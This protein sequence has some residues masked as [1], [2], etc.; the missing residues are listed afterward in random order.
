M[1][2]PVAI[3]GKSARRAKAVHRRRVLTVVSAWAR[4]VRGGRQPGVGGPRGCQPGDAPV[5]T[6]P[7]RMGFTGFVHD[8]TPEAV[9]ASRTLV[10]ENGDILTHHI[11]GVPWA[12]A[13]GGGP[14]P[15]AFLD[16]W[17]G[18]KS[19]TPPG[20][21]VYLAISPGRGELK[22]AEKAGPIPKELAGK[23]YDDPVVMAACLNYCRRAI[24]FFK[25]DYLCIGI[26]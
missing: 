12:E 3:D 11:E 23:S 19:A 2:V 16:E 10:R 21:K 26:M 1:L 20:G 18:K 9:A 17:E 5:G 14:F 8:I 22:P 25:P 15:K 6:R 13:H 4:G 24:E 7:F